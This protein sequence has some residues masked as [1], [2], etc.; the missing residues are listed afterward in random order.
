[1]HTAAPSTTEDTMQNDSIYISFAS[2]HS[3]FFF[4]LI[5][6]KKFLFVENNLPSSLQVIE[7][8][9]LRA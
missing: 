3:S 2:C 4:S 1:M 7:K 5:E 9:L 8:N 6:G